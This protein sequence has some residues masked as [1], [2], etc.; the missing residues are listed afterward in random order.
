LYPPRCKDAQTKTASLINLRTAGML[1]LSTILSIV[2][3]QC[4]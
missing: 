4:Y 1:A 3:S 2:R